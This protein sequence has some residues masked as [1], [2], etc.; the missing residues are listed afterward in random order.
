METAHHTTFAA[1]VFKTGGCY[2]RIWIVWTSRDKCVRADPGAQTMELAS[3][4][5]EMGALSR[6]VPLERRER[7]RA[8][9]IVWARSFFGWSMDR[10]DVAHLLHEQNRVLVS[11]VRIP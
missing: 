6:A 8:W 3:R 5:S 11:W 10:S 2:P 4:R 9:A 7:A 1:S